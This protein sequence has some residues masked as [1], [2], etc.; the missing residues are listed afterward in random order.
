MVVKLRQKMHSLLSLAKSYVNR[1]QFSEQSAVARTSHGLSRLTSLSLSYTPSLL[2]SSFLVTGLLV[3]VRQTGGLQFL[4]LLA[5]DQIVRSQPQR[6][7]D[8]RLLVVGITESDIQLQKQ[9]PLSD[10]VVAQLL[11]NLQQGQPRVIGLDLYRDVPHEPGRDRLLKALA[12]PNVVIISQLG[13]SSDRVPAPPGIPPERI[14]FSDFVIDPDNVVRRNLMHVQSSSGEQKYYSFAIQISRH[15]LGQAI[16]LSVQPQKLTIG[17]VPF[18]RLQT[19]SGGYRLPPSEALGWQILLKYRSR[20]VARQ[21]TLEQALAGQIDASWLQGKVV[22]IGVTALSEKDLFPNP[23]SAA[24]TKNSEMP[25]VVIHAQMVSQILS[26]VLQQQRLFW[27]LPEWGEW[28]WIW[29]WSLL[30]GI[31][32]WCCHRPWSL[33]LAVAIAVGGLWGVCFLAFSQSGWLP[34]IPPL[35]GLLATGASLLAYKVVYRTYHDPLTGLPNRRLFVQQLKKTYVGQP[36]AQ[37]ALSA[38]LFLDLDRFK[39]INDGLGH[40]AGDYLLFMAAQRLQKLLN[41]QALL[42]RVGGDEFAI[43]LKA[44]ADLREATDLADRI[45]ENLTQPF[46]WQGQDIFTTVS[47]GITFNRSGKEIQAEELLRYADIAMYKAK[48]LGKA[49]HEVFAAG[50]DTLAVRRWQLES[51]LRSA[52]KHQE[53][54]LYYQ[55]IICLKT[56]KISG[57]EALVRWQ[58]PQ[59]GFVS[60]GEFIPVAE[61]TGLI[62][63]LGQWIMREACRQMRAW[64]QKFPQNPPLIISVNL[65]S[66]QFCQPDLVKQIQEILQEVKLDRD[67]LKLEITESMMMNDV[68]LAINLLQRL[69]ALGLRLSIDDFGT[70]YSSLSYLHRFPVDTL[71]IDKSFVGRMDES[72]EDEKYT[73]IVRTI[74]AL[75]HNLS[76]NVIAEGIETESQMQVLKDLNCE[77][78]QGYFFAKPLS[79]EAATHCLSEDCKW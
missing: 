35:V 48:E 16:P 3:G 30:G 18:A 2:L 64:Q 34:L 20:M 45:Q 5:L 29:I 40:E 75:G 15:Y 63:P 59:R 13:S 24:Q 71:K 60:P 32:V 28:I 73:Q 21:V 55:P 43:W 4:E 8:P 51:D 74:I 46:V 27:Y 76:L 65:S 26:T 12:A 38:V 19:N 23:Y 68:E 58:S 61:E 69:K 7:L 79:S 56:G 47:I 70:G 22:L 33:G 41:S 66:R 6:D 50:M 1:R 11:E 72:K 57:F 10:Q 9:W 77:Y 44:I 39:L 49:R 42:A 36:S 54:Q 14:G 78:G 52:L 53:F 67:S 62:V 25:G 31:L 37:N 17:A